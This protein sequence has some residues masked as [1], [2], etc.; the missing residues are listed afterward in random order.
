MEAGAGRRRGGVGNA[1][2]RAL[3][4]RRAGPRISVRPA[5]AALAGAIPSPAGSA[6]SR[7]PGAG[8][9][10][11]RVRP[12]FP[13][14]GAR[15]HPL[16]VLPPAGPARPPNRR[17]LEAARARILWNPAPQDLSAAIAGVLTD[18]P[19]RR[20]EKRPDSRP[21]GSVSVLLLG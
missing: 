15:A 11:P 20:R 7:D 6:A 12:P 17:F 3:G 13:R 8:R 16:E 4:G 1:R 14:S 10:G 19:E 2:L 5:P 21:P 9:G 18:L